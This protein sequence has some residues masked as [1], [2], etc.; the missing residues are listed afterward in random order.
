MSDETKTEEEP[1]AEAS[2]ET[3]KPEPPKANWEYKKEFGIV[4][5]M[6][7]IVLLTKEAHEIEVERLRRQLEKLTYGS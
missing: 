6:R 7:E 2:A 4:T 3:P 5:K 1:K